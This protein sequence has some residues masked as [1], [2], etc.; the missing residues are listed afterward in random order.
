MVVIA[1]AAAAVLLIFVFFILP[2]LVMPDEV[3]PS[4]TDTEQAAPPGNVVVSGSIANDTGNERSPFAEAQ[5]SAPVSYT[6]LTLP[7]K[8]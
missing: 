8:A 7:T 3:A 5:E 6:H 1:L 4:L 2:Q